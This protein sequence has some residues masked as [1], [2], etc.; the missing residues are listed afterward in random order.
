MRGN[1]AARAVAELAA[2]RH[3]AYARRL[4]ATV[5]FTKGMAAVRLRRGDLTEPVPG[6]LLIAGTPMTYRT[7]LSIAVQ[8]G[9]GTVASHRASG[10]LH[11]FD[12][13]I[14]GAPLEVTVQSGRYPEIDGVTVHRAKRLDPCDITLVDGIPVT[15]IA[16]TLCDLGAVVDQDTVERSLDCA[17]RR[18][19]S[20]RWIEEVLGR[21]D[22]PG[23]SGTATLRRILDDPRRQG[24]LP[25]S[26]LERLIKRASAHPDLPELVMQ[27]EV[28]DP[29][30]GRRVAVLDG[31]FPEWRIGVEG[32]SKKFHGY[33]T[34]REW[35]D[36]ERDNALGM[37]GYEIVYVTWPLA[38]D[39]DRFCD[40]VLRTHQARQRAAV[41]ID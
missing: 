30:T 29:R 20:L 17:L 14:D 23:P 34:K 15:S 2:T 33:G 36:L 27:H 10:H 9:G 37:L 35:L 38:N 19:Y 28:R 32:H 1:D 22:R 11:A 39:P 21:V 16:R 5:G 7:R 26:W 18:G 25:D 8:A 13:F 40:T 6:V 24:G 4:A 3:G 41:G 12:D 31:C